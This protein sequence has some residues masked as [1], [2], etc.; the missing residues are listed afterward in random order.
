L[1]LLACNCN[2]GA[3]SCNSIVGPDTECRL[4]DCN[5]SNWGCG[6]LWMGECTGRCEMVEIH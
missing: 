1:D 2:D 3:F 4:G 6:F 5:P